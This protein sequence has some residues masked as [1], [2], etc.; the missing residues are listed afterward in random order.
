MIDRGEQAI[1]VETELL[2][3]QRPCIMDRL[4]LE[5]VPERKIAEHF[6]EGVVPRGV[7]HIVEVIVLAACTHAL[8][9]A[10]CAGR[11]GRFEPGEDVLERHHARVDE[12]QRRIVMR[13]QWRR[14]DTLVIA[15]FEEFEEGPAD[16][17]G[18]GHDPAELGKKAVADK[19]SQRALMRDHRCRLRQ[20]S[21]STAPDNGKTGR[22]ASRGK[23]RNRFSG[24]PGARSA[25]PA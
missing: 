15:R 3:Q 16:V 19:L 2:G 7:A 24:F 1:F 11:R 10:N 14:G 22:E 17:V 23:R 21:G 25:A 12:H 6:E 8:L 5:V 18:A 13:H 20:A 9:R 4:F